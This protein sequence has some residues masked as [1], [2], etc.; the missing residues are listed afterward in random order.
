M[1][2]FMGLRKPTV[3]T[4]STSDIIFPR[5]Y[6]MDY[7][8][9]PRYW[10]LRATIVRN[11]I[12]VKFALIER[13]SIQYR[14]L[15]PPPSAWTL[16]SLPPPIVHYDIYDWRYVG[17]QWNGQSHVSHT[18]SNRDH[19][20]LIVFFKSMCRDLSLTIKLAKCVGT[21]DRFGKYLR[22]IL[23]IL[24]YEKHAYRQILLI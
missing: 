17:I 23:R 18:V 22:H 3:R 15:Q 12:P 9:I 2:A 5:L 14:Y 13:D 6:E 21:A 8:L 24:A 20:W 4:V 11:F 1:C 16:P 7:P 10:Y 19:A